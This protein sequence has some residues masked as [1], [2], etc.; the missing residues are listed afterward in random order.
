[1]LSGSRKLCDKAV[2]TYLSTIEYVSDQFKTQEMCN[3]AVNDF[4]PVLNLFLIGFLQLI[5]K[6]LLLYMPMKI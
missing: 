6:L 5:K 2:D 1:M 3:K 4:L